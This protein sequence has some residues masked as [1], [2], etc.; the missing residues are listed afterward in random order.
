MSMWAAVLWTALAAAPSASAYPRI[1]AAR[2]NDP[3]FKQ[4]QAALEEFYRQ[5]GDASSLVLYRYDPKPSSTLIAVAAR[6]GLPYSAVASLNGLNRGTPLPE[7][8]L[9]PSMPGLFVPVKPETDTELVMAD[10]RADEIAGR[11]PVTIRRR[12]ARR[13][14]FLPGRDFDRVERLSYLGI[15][16][17]RPVR[18]TEI[19]SHYGYRRSPFTG[20]PSFHS[21]ADFVAPEGTEV[22]AARGGEVIAVGF[23]EVYGRFVRLR[24]ENGYETFYSHL[25]EVTVELNQRIS[26]GMM[27]GTIGNTGLSTGPHLHFE[28]RLNGES[29]DPVRHLPGLEE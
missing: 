3:I 7:E 27:L 23:H 19:S 8:L 25:D 2:H 4:Q 26:S 22:Q 11:S 9:I 24:H 15:L 28:I 21:G 10:R 20:K 5:G 29:R 14:Y 16:F 18:N 12:G 6:F 17:R 13:F 1:E